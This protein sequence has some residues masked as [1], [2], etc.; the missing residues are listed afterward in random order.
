MENSLKENEENDTL[1]YKCNN[2]FSTPK[3]LE[4]KNTPKSIRKLS[5]SKKQYKESS[6]IPKKYSKFI[7]KKKYNN[8]K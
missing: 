6:F 7:S 8:S 1:S 2:K 3:I 4:N 5:S